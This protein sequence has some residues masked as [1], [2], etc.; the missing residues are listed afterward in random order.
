LHARKCALITGRM[1]A[2][3]VRLRIWVPTLH[4]LVLWLVFVLVDL[5]TT[6]RNSGAAI[7]LACPNTNV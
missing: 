4:L 6:I 2:I 5:P 7:R 3:L 1:T